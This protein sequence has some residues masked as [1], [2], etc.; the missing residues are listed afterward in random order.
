MRRGTEAILGLSL[1]WIVVS[2]CASSAARRTQPPRPLPLAMTQTPAP[3]LR[4]PGGT[5]F[6]TQKS[7]PPAQTVIPAAAP[8]LAP[9][10][11]L[12]ALS[13]LAREASDR[14]AG[15][16]SY[17]VRMK[18]R[19][20]VSGKNEPEELILLKFRKQPWSVHMKWIGDEAKGREVVHVK[21]H[22]GDKLHTRLA[23]GDVP[24]MPAGKRMAF[25]PNSSLVRSS[26]RHPITNAGIGNLIE[27]FGLVV[28][29]VERGDTSLGTLKYLGLIQRPEFGQPCEAAEHVIP[30]GREP[31]L[32]KGGTRWRFFDP[33]TR[34]P[35][36]LI[37]HDH[38]GQPVEYYLYDRFE[39]NVRLDDDDFNPDKLWGK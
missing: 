8:A 24:F 21:G 36:L 37:T 26:S 27:K 2:G 39:F 35:S 34:F 22:H 33:V 9:A 30:G 7:P 5:G 38:T 19:E 25:D 15:V 31:A 17:I 18:R 11:P 13:K 23:A 4:M 1:T 12:A 10:N 14:Y 20:Q 28:A 16:E 6:A 3:D 29:A 32:P